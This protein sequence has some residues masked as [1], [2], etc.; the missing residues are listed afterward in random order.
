[1]K[2]GANCQ[3]PQLIIVSPIARPMAKSK[4]RYRD[5]TKCMLPCS[6]SAL[7]CKRREL[8]RSNRAVSRPA[9]VAP[10]AAECRRR[11]GS[12][13]PPRGNVTGNEGGNDREDCCPEIVPPIPS[14]EEMVRVE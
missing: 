13:R 1:M 10:P 7:D 2:S 6:E 12:R 4:A 3:C 9:R 11:R 8:R 5:T 14:H